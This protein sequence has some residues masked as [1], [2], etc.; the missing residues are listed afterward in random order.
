M[1]FSITQR[2]KKRLAFT[3]NTIRIIKRDKP[4]TSD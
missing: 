1:P 2:E 4:E 3:L